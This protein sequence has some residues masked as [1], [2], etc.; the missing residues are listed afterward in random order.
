MLII[1]MLLSCSEMAETVDFGCSLN[2][3]SL[4]EAHTLWECSA[5]SS[6]EMNL[7][8]S[9]YCINY[10]TYHIVVNDNEVI[11]IEVTYYSDKDQKNIE[12]M[13]AQYGESI[14]EYD[15]YSLS[16]DDLFEEINN[17]M[18]QNPAKAVIEYDKSYGFPTRASFDMDV[19]IA[20]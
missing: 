18:S 6:Y 20:D 3:S 8:I 19:M 15:Y 11:R 10:L 16:I 17:R 13:E 7:S 9:C 14:W 2:P 5:I 1:Y 4:S 12:E